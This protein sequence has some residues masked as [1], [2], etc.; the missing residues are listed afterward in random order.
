[1]LF[2]LNNFMIWYFL[3]PFYH[4][5]DYLVNKKLK[6][7]N[8]L[9]DYRY[10]LY[11]YIYIPV[12]MILKFLINKANSEY[13]IYVYYFLFIILILL[14]TMQ[15]I[16]LYKRQKL[17]FFNFLIIIYI[18]IYNIAIYT[19]SG[20]KYNILYY[21]FGEIVG[22]IAIGFLYLLMWIIPIHLIIYLSIIIYQQIIK[23]Y[24]LSDN[25]NKK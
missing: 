1:M 8:F 3:L 14:A 5:Y 19:L 20:T 11:I 6:L 2:I 24:I 9:K 7:N 22:W 23:K 18:Y 25:Y 16:L 10:L 15:L 4:L 17:I 21:I 12:N 13:F